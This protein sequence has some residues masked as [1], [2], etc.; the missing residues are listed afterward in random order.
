MKYA[1]F[2]EA[3]LPVAFYDDS[4]QAIPDEAVEITVAQ[5]SEMLANQ[6]KRR[7]NGHALEE[8]SSA[9]DPALVLAFIKG[10]AYDVILAIVPMWKQINMTAKSVE[11]ADKKAQG[12][13]TDEEVALSEQIRAVWAKTEAVRAK[14]D[15]LEE[16][17]VLAADN[18]SA[19][20][21]ATIRATLA[22]A[23]NPEV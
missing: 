10:A 20:D 16:A 9:F 22:A 4:V 3:G 11:I 6:G 7:W 15:E 19:D 21:K 5:W 1:K 14:S 18:L 8:Y 12:T 2:D 17:Y 23:A 13:A